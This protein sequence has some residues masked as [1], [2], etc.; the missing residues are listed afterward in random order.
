[1]DPL[2]FTL[3]WLNIKKNSQSQLKVGWFEFFD[4]DIENLY[5]TLAKIEPPCTSPCLKFHPGLDPGADRNPDLA[6]PPNTR[7]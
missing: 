3:Q 7:F 4:L 2:P 5:C 6:A 1:M